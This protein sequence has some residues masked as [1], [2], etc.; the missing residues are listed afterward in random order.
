MPHH[1]SKVFIIGSGPAGYTAAIYSARASLEPMIVAGIQ[2]GGQMTITTDVENYPGFENVVQG[3]WLM[4]QMQKQAEHVGT[5]MIY[6]IIP[7]VDLSHRP[8]RQKVIQ[9]ILILAIQSL[10]QP[11]R[12]HVGSAYHR[13]RSSW[14]LASPLATPATVSSSERKRSRLLEAV[15]QR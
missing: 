8:F 13:K 4:E 3:P 9:E 2:P 6:D 1:H 10:S 11:V 7:E 5:R 14:V 12:R 15:T